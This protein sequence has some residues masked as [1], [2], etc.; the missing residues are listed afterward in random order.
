MRAGAPRSDDLALALELLSEKSAPKPSQQDPVLPDEHIANE[1]IAT[2]DTATV[3]EAGGGEGKL[4]QLHHSYM[5]LLLLHC[6]PYFFKNVSVSDT[7]N[8]RHVAVR[9]GS[10]YKL[11]YRSKPS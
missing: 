4:W 7:L 6:R 11:L 2:G 8:M 1:E 5:P 3:S 9:A 10:N